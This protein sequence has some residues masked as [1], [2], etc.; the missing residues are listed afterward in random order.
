MPAHEKARLKEMSSEPRDDSRGE[1]P[2]SVRDDEAE[3]MFVATLSEDDRCFYEGHKGL[4]NS[5]KA[6]VAWL[7]HCGHE[8]QEVDVQDFL[9]Q[10]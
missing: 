5:Q 10:S 7:E 4:G 6:E 8:Y 1:N 9:G 3:R 2:G